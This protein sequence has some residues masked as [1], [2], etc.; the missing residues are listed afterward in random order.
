MAKK[1]TPLEGI[2]RDPENKLIVQKVNPLFYLGRSDLSLAEL[3]IMDMYL[4][5]IN[6]R[7]PNQR[8]IRLTK[9]QLEEA[10][11]VTRI[12]R[13]D[14]EQR[15]RNLHQPIDLA[16]G[17][18]KRVHLIGLFEEAEAEQDEDGVWQISLTCTPAAM[19]YIFKAELLGYFRYGLRS[20]INLSS[21]YSYVL[22]T[23]LERNRFRGK[24]DIHL[25]DLKYELKC[26]GEE[27]YKQFKRFN[28]LILKKCQKEIHEKTECRFAY[29][30]IRRGRSVA[31]IRF[32]LETIPAIEIPE[33][34]PNQFT[35]FEGD[36]RDAICHG[37]SQSEFE[38]F[39][40]DQLLLL[41]DLGW[42]KKDEE[43]VMRHKD[44]LGDMKLACEF[45]TADYLRRQIITAKT[46]N[47]KKLFLYVK[48]MIENDK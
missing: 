17:E 12:N 1:K 37:F 21:R 36:G 29:E 4:A 9:G 7:N 39:T 15:L 2:G 13:D 26:D 48:K 41:K 38:G 35:F 24:W 22:F 11:G 18:K 34:D 6:T 5:R 46:K 44:V 30:P 19:K 43:A 10:L 31:S 33:V 45:A 42:E 23:Y 25:D 3:K 40:N 20:I 8:T 27:T 16:N 28:D 14:L 47:P 32:K